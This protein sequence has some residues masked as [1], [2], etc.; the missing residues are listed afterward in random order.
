MTTPQDTEPQ[1]RADAQEQTWVSQAQ[2]GDL[3]A[4]NAIV[5]R[6]QQ[7]AYNLA[8]RMLR[9]PSLAEDVTQEG[10]FSAYRNIGRFRGGSLKSWI[11]TIVANRARDILRSPTRSRTSSLEEFT[12]GGDPGG[13][14]AHPDDPPEQQAERNETTR[15]VQDAIAH[16]PEDQRLVIT[17]VD[18]QQMDYEEA[19]R[20]TNVSLGTV[21]SRLFRGRQRLKE[22]LRPV[23][24]LSDSA[25]RQN[26]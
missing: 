14:W 8:L 9:D 16:L 7:F 22:S 6:Y 19:A 4:F 20:I 1:S 11:L 10:F 12:E 21:K 2:Q 17:L 24:E 25:P 15:A 5:E 26:Q 18:L 3:L 23:W 13:P